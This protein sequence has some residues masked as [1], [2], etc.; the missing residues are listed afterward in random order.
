[1]FNLRDRFSNRTTFWW[2]KRLWN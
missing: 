1:V 2:A